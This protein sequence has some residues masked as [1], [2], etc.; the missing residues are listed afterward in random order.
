MH[1]EARLRACTEHTQLAVGNE[2]VVGLCRSD[3]ILAA[4]VRSGRRALADPKRLGGMALQ[5]AE[6][7]RAVAAG[8]PAGCEL[9][10]KQVTCTWTH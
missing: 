2:L 4:Q 10:G 5:R 9:R 3:E 7:R 1:V 8:C 6:K